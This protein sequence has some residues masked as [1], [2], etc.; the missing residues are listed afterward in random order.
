MTAYKPHPGYLAEQLQSFVEQTHKNWFCVIRSDSDISEFKGLPA[1][2]EL[3][4]DPRITLKENTARLGLVKNFEAAL[5][6][7]LA[8]SPDAVAFSDQDDIWL[9]HKLE[10]QIQVLEK[11]P[12][13]SL[14]HTNMLEL[15]I[16]EGKE[17]LSDRTVWDIEHRHVI[18]SDFEH[19]LMRNIV[20]GATLMMD[21]DLAQSYKDIPDT[22]NVH[23]YWFA[24][25]ASLHGG[26]YPITE[27]LMKYRQHG[28]NL[29]GVN[30]QLQMN[31]DMIF[32]LPNKSRAKFQ[33]TLKM[34]KSFPSVKKEALKLFIK[35][36]RGLGLLG[37]SLASMMKDPV[38][39][40]NAF[41]LAVG[42]FINSMGN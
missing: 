7:V 11:C 26:V 28:H 8:Q 14:V 19:L 18:N 4:K 24:L 9:I 17:T 6:D 32:D 42:K 1:I 21:F 12:P 22:M 31:K 34:L 16:S 10:R 15:R 39:A 37:F 40:K 36:D 25:A 38:L 20:T 23:D 30:S 27:P 2:A 5:K 33:K 13:M 41:A 3:L 35:S 29:V